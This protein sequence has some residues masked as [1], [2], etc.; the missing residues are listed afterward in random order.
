MYEYGHGGNAIYESGKENTIDLSANINPFGIPEI[1]KKAMVCEVS[2]CDRYPDSFSVQ[3]REKIAEFEHVNLDWIFCGNGASDIIFRLP[4]AMYAKKVMITAPAFSDYERAAR[5]Y[6]ADII[7]HTLLAADD[8]TWNS[9]LIEAVLR[10]KPNLVFVCNP[11]NPTGNITE[12][13]LMKDLLDCC[14]HVGAWLAVDECFLD[15]VEQA[16]EYTGKVFLERYS[17]LVIIKAFTKMFALPGIRLGYAI[18][19]DAL[20]INSLYAHGADWPVSNLAQA[21]GIAALESAEHFIKKTVDFVSSERV[22][23]ETELFRL[24]YKVFPSKANYVFIQSPYSFDLREELDKR[25][26]RIRSC[27]NYHG[28]DSSYYRI[29]VSEKSKNIKFLNAITEITKFYNRNLL[30]NS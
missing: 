6:G 26:I 18:C 13:T 20:L 14:R 15:F 16:E 5:S 9:G 4:R 8:F 21:A 22:T 30:F 25:G 24:G 23:V 7:R 10:S 12:C 28:L 11:N 3:L 2:G 19:S 17:N 27:G 1:V 29:A